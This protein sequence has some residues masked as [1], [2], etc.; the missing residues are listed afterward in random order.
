MQETMMTYVHEEQQ[1]CREILNNYERNLASFQQI[2]NKKKPR[3]WLILATGSSANAMLSVKYYIEKVADVSI[4]IQEPFNFVHYG[5]IRQSADF[6]L[7]VSQGGHSYST[8]EALKKVYRED[9]VPTAVLTSKLDSP[10]AKYADTVIDIGCGV[11]KVGFVTKGF[12]ATV[13]TSLLMGILAGVSYGEVGVKEK[14]RKLDELNKAIEHIPIIIRKT[15]QFYT[16]HWKEL[17]SIPRFAIVGYGPSVGT[18]KEGETKFTE[19]IRVPT[20]GFELEAY[21]HGPYLEVNKNYSLI[22]LKTGG[23]LAERMEKLKEYFSSYTEHCFSISMNEE[24]ER[25]AKT[26]SLDIES[27]ELLSPLFMAIPLQIL[28]YRIT[29]G[30][31]IDLGVRIFDDFDKVLKSKV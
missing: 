30:K 1:V 5:K 21:M 14:Q 9:R 28:A 15:E 13:L 12:T 24:S 25:D 22:F 26:L 19:T 2:I 18:A 29:T 27:N 7:A 8:I 6:V 11:E 17:N 16:Q 10:I 31:G 3:N 20:Q 4:E 23:V